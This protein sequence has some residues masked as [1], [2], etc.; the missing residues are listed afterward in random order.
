MPKAV[1]FTHFVMPS[2]TDDL[3]SPVERR[4]VHK[5]C[6]RLIGSYQACP[7]VGLV[8]VFIADGYE[9]IL[10]GRDPWP[11]LDRERRL[12]R[13]FARHIGRASAA[14]FQIVGTRELTPTLACLARHVEL[15]L[16]RL[17]LGGGQRMYYDSPK[18]VEAIIRLARGFRPEPILR[19]DADVMVN[20]QAMQKLLRFHQRVKGKEVYFFSGCYACH[21]AT[22][23]QNRLLNDYAVRVQY[24]SHLGDRTTRKYVLK[25]QLAQRFLDELQEVGADQSGQVISGAG[26]CMSFQA[27]FALPPFA[28]VGDQVVWIDDHLKRRLHEQVGHLGHNRNCRCSKAN[29]LQHRYPAGVRPEDVAWGRKEYL[30]RLARGCVMDAL[31]WDRADNGPGP[32]AQ[33]VGRYLNFGAIPSREELEKSLT[34]PAQSRLNELVQLWRQ[35][36]YRPCGPFGFAGRLSGQARNRL[37]RQVIDAAD[38]YFKLLRMWKDLKEAVIALPREETDNSWLFRPPV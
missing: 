29:F 26:L 27:I 5:Q 18:F 8:Y 1:V 21:P 15:D 33:W 6:E 9:A 23:K 3:L 2:G 4:P 22:M 30:P 7:S 20:E 14:K 32:F 36:E 13:I 17:L 28:N 25:E 31:I 16:A 34:G 12:R 24:L 11:A 38:Q 19:F 10:A 37:V 35:P